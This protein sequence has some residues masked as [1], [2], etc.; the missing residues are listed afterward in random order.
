LHNVLALWSWNVSAKQ[1]RQVP[2]VLSLNLPL[3][4]PWHVVA[5]GVLDVPLGQSSHDSSGGVL[6]IVPAL[7]ASNPD[8]VEVLI[9]DPSGTITAVDPPPATTC[10][11]STAMHV[12]ALVSGWYVPS[13][14]GLHVIL[15]EEEAYV[16]GL[17][18]KQLTAP[19]PFMY[20][21]TLQPKQLSLPD[22][23]WCCPAAHAKH[24]FDPVWFS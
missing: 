5:P 19:C 4:Q 8:R 20:C 17:H 22:A 15:P 14:H 11:S 7:H 16:P 3:S 21:P 12:V 23:A 24:F 18:F 2:P 6:P 10:P 13:S 9:L 1:L